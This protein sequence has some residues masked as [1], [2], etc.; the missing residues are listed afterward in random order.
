MVEGHLMH[1]GSASLLLFL[2]TLPALAALGQPQIPDPDTQRV[3]AEVKDVELPSGD[4]PT[5]EEEKTL[6]RCVSADLYFGFGQPADPVKARKCAHVEMKKGE[7]D[8]VFGGRAIL[9]MVYA[10]G[11][12]VA[13]NFDVALKL[14]CEIGGAP[15]DIAGRVRRLALLKE[16]KWTGS[17]FSICDYSAG[18]YL[19]DQCAILQERFDK[20]ERD[21]SLNAIIAKWSA[22][23][24]KAFRVL[25]AKAQEFFKVRVGMEIDLSGTPEVHETAFLERDLI[26]TL[27]QF[28]RG[29]LPKFSGSEFSKADTAMTSAYSR[30][31]TGTASQ[32]G[33]VNREGIKKA[34][35]AWIL[36]RDAW[37]NFGRTKYPGVST[38]SWKTWLTL[39]RT[40]MLDRFLH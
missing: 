30:T 6:A 10:N 32:W 15:V 19:Y 29:E 22:A 14:A 35:Q 26:S 1:K 33:T 11:K 23:N 27:E 39:R 7:K 2:S 21:K 3:C 20:V 18:K 25:Q 38:E 31:Q 12:G 16:E 9:M 24:K 36:Y 8:L 28:E 34:Q 5:P 40:E 4:R 13:R 37:V 17:T